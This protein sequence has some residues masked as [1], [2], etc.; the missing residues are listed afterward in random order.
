MIDNLIDNLNQLC[1]KYVLDERNFTEGDEIRTV[2]TEIK[3][4]GYSV[5]SEPFDKSVIIA[6]SLSEIGKVKYEKML[7][8][9]QNKLEKVEIKDFESAADFRDL[10]RQFE[11]E[12]IFDYMKNEGVAYFKITDQESKMI[13]CWLYCEI[14]TRFFRIAG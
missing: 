7:I 3:K 10:E 5:Y 9:R 8:M 4:L 1:R 12:V 11:R 13:G 14:L 6:G 2:F